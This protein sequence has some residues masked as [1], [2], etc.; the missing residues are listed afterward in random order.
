MIIAPPITPGEARLESASAATLVPTIDF[1]GTEPQRLH[2]LLER[3]FHVA[4]F[5]MSLVIFSIGDSRSESNQPV[6][7][8][9]GSQVARIG[10]LMRITSRIRSV[11]MNGIT[12]RKMVA[13]VTSCTT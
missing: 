10:K 12:P 8:R 7:M 9:E 3:A 13:K 11:M 1:Q 4:Q 2:F 5:P 6:Y